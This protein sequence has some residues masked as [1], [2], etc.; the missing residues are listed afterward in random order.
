MLKGVLLDVRLLLLLYLFK[1]VSATLQCCF[2]G[3]YK[4]YLYSYLYVYTY[5]SYICAHYNL[6]FN[7]S[8]NYIIVVNNKTKL[9]NYHK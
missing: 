3:F 5:I 9:S 6:L 7:L 1:L 4:N 8:I 2:Y